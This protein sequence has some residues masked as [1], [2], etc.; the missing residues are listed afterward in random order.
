M[1][2]II[3][4]TALLGLLFVL[5]TQMS[6]A[7]PPLRHLDPKS[8]HFRYLGAWQAD[9][10]IPHTIYPGSRIEF[11]LKGK[12]RLQ[13]KAGLPD[14][15]KIRIER[16]GKEA[17]CGRI[18]ES[19]VEIDGGDVPSLFS[20]IYVG[21]KRMEFDASAADAKGAE[22]QFKGLDLE[23][24]GM[25]GTA[26]KDRHSLRIEFIGDSITVGDVIHGRDGA[27]H[28]NSDVTLTYS[29]ILGNKLGVPYS[30]RAFPGSR[31]SDWLDRFPFF[32]KSIP[33]HTTNPPDVVFVNIGANSRHDGATK[34]F[35][36]M[37]A[38][39]D[40]IFD[41][42][43]QTKVVLLNF[44]RM[45]PERLPVHQQLC[46]SYPEG[47]VL[48]FDAR[49]YLVGYS[50]SNLHPNVESHRRLAIALERF[51]MQNLMSNAGSDA[52]SPAVPARE[53]P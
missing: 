36:D 51:V 12:A 18:G 29:Y 21:C 7:G 23:A 35:R 3:R 31:A 9:G 25:A 37:N 6:M 49:P 39:L 14:F 24:D 1:R 27:W 26:P 47:R 5:A 28:E 8:P 20:V 16:N 40:L 50:D 34:H 32:Q 19:D 13:I 15:V 38:L 53:S 52:P 45:T 43:P 17:W 10:T 33:V 41:T 30:L 44:F 11:C 48:S 2:R 42:Y 4:T 22:F 46:R